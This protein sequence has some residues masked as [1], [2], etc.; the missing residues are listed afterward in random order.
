MNV[1]SQ[2]FPITRDNSQLQFVTMRPIPGATG[3]KWE[4]LVTRTFGDLRWKPLSNWVPGPL[5]VQLAVFTNDYLCRAF[6]REALGQWLPAYS[7]ASAEVS[8]GA[9]NWPDPIGAGPRQA[10]PLE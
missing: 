4:G 3:D 1:G 10:A 7:T 5:I 9:L 6:S 8:I 2:G